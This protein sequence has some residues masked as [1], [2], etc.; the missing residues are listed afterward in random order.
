MKLELPNILAMSPLIL[1]FLGCAHALAAACPRRGGGV[2]VLATSLP[3]LS[4]PPPHR[5]ATPRTTDIHRSSA[6]A[7][8]CVCLLL[9]SFAAAFAPPAAMA[10]RAVAVVSPAAE[11][12]MFLGGKKVRHN[13]N[14]PIS[15][16]LM[17][18]KAPMGTSDLRSLSG[19][20]L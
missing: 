8:T 3:L 4:S 10:P 5:S 19:L 15:V 12:H 16:S 17:S 2:R 7:L 18:V 14:A 9:C 1:A 20:D 13:P 6:P 11:V